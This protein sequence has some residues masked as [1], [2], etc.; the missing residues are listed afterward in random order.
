MD[1]VKFG[2][3]I[4]KKR[5]E[6]GLTQA[7][8]GSLVN[9]SDKAVSKWETGRGSPD[10]D[11]LVPL[12]NV[13]G[14]SV[15][16]L[17]N[18]RSGSNKTMS[19]KRFLKPYICI[20]IIITI[21]ISNF[22][23]YQ[24]NRYAVYDCSTTPDNFT[25]EGYS[26]LNRNKFILNIESISY[27]EPHVGTEKEEVHDLTLEVYY[28]DYKIYERALNENFI[29]SNGIHDALKN[30]HISS[31]NL[32]NKEIKFSKKYPQKISLL[33]KYHNGGSEFIKHQIV[34]NEN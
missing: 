16:D 34:L 11:I 14:I 8:L 33:I 4:K 12:A 3:F 2:K 13:F 21:I 25:L 5:N 29:N 24:L 22:A 23:T 17:L 32:E 19:Y 7:D 26:L 6:L 20:I 28:G 1:Q 18:Q 30:V 9:L 10:I 31:D 15:D 27:N